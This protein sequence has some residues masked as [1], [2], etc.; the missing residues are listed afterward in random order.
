[1][2]NFLITKQLKAFYVSIWAPF[3]QLIYNRSRRIVGEGNFKTLKKT[4]KYP[5]S[6]IIPILGFK[7]NRVNH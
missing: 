5:F 3:I 6:V 7:Y 1:M 4:H 2:S